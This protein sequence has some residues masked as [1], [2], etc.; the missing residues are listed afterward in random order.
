MYKTGELAEIVGCS[1]KTIR[2]K[3]NNGEITVAQKLF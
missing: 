1:T 3:V 2:Q